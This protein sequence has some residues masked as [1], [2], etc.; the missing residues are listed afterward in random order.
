MPSSVPLYGAKPHGA[1]QRHQT[2]QEIRRTWGTRPGIKA[3]WSKAEGCGEGAGL[4]AIDPLIA[5]SDRR[6]FFHAF[7]A[8]LSFVTCRYVSRSISL[9]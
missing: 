8:N 6:V 9:T 3:L 4:S 5:L 1:C 2:Q 7:D